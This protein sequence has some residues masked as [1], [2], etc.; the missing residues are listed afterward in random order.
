MGCL[1]AHRDIDE[2]KM[3]QNQRSTKEIVNALA[4]LHPRFLPL[5][6]DYEPANP[7][8]PSGPDG[9]FF[10]FRDKPGLTQ[11]RLLEIHDRCDE[12][13]NSGGLP[14]LKHEREATIIDVREVE[15]L[16][17]E[18]R[19]SLWCHIIGRRDWQG[20]LLCRFD[21]EIPEGVEVASIESRLPDYPF[22]VESKSNELDPDHPLS[23][24][25]ELIENSKKRLSDLKHLIDTH[26]AET[27]PVDR[28]DT[29]TDRRYGFYKVKFVPLPKEMRRAARDAIRDLRDALDHAAYAC[30]DVQKRTPFNTSFPLHPEKSKFGPKRSNEGIRPE[31]LDVMLSYKGYGDEDGNK[32]LY[33]ISDIRNSDTHRLLSP[34]GFMPLS[35]GAPSEMRLETIMELCQ[36]GVTDLITQPIIHFPPL[37]DARSHEMTL[38]TFDQRVVDHIEFHVTPFICFG[39]AGELGHLMWQPPVGSINAMIDLVEGIVADVRKKAEEIGLFRAVGR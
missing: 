5:A 14:R 11:T 34:F 12:A 3:R 30:A 15:S 29:M 9:F 37:W 33:A 19:E 10:R 32:L 18:L 7:S 22:L 39:E 6:T 27:P 8:D 21:H 16:A 36:S 26:I 17:Q 4:G 2:V 23:S 13:L 31:I 28:V 1:V 24:A 35:W 38:V 25:Y 20:G